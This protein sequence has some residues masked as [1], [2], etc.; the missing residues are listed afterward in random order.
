MKKHQHP[1]FL[2]ESFRRSAEI[3]EQVARMCRD[4][5][6]QS[7]ERISDRPRGAAGYRH[8]AT[9]GDGTIV[10]LRQV[11]DSELCALQL[12]V[13]RGD[14]RIPVPAQPPYITRNIPDDQV[15][16]ESE[17]IARE[18]AAALMTAGTGVLVS[19]HD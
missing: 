5:E 19:A 8:I 9:F 18:L 4:V 1:E 3:C 15:A 2:V 17:A 11:K 13:E 6:A 14:Q 12:I 16:R 7:T 10:S